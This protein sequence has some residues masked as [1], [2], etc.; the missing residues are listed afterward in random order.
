ML[1]RRAKTT[2]PRGGGGARDQA[3]PVYGILPSHVHEHRSEPGEQHVELQRRRIAKSL[4]GSNQGLGKPDALSDNTVLIAGWPRPRQ[5][6]ENDDGGHTGGAPREDRAK[7][8]CSS[9]LH[10]LEAEVA[11]E[12]LRLRPMVHHLQGQ[13]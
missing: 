10:V 2:N 5:K 11:H 4:V 8:L 7:P 6:V 13:M 9:A 1:S 12:D 3:R